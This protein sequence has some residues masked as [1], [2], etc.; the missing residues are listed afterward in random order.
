MRIK[1]FPGG[2][3]PPEEKITSQISI[4]ELS[5]PKRVVIPLSQHTGIPAQPIVKVGDSVKT[6]QKIGEA[7][8]AISSCVHASISGKI[9][10][11][12]KY[13]HPLG[14]GGVAIT[15]DSDGKDE[16]HPSIKHNNNYFRLHPNEIRTIVRQAGIVGL[17]GAAFPTYVKLSPPKDRWIDS[18]ILNGCECEP[19]LTCDHRLMVE[20]TYE[21]IQGLQ[22]MAKTLGD[23]FSYIGIEDNKKDAIGALKGA[24]RNEANIEVVPLKTKYPQGSEKQLIRAV[25]DRRVPSGGLPLD[26]GVVVQNVGT[27]WAIIDAVKRGRPLIE[28]VITVTGPGIKK[29]ANLK[30]RIGTLFQDVIDYCGGFKGKPGKIIMGGPLM[31]F[32]QYTPL[33]PVIKGTTGIVV[34]PREAVEETSPRSCI[35]CARCVDSCPTDIFP[36]LIAQ[37]AGKDKFDWAKEYGALDCIECGVCSYLC[38][39][40]I[41]LVQLIKYAK[42]QIKKL[43]EP[44]S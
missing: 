38:P 37:Y 31:G 29:P 41:P 23:V 22:L 19:Y 15:I 34:L 10:S 39:A 28:R 13:P 25:L 20:R 35:R 16:L 11:I 27:A 3:H 36:N 26:V 40:K 33:V 12:E 1:T 14:P 8:G 18:L 32:A 43:I 4:Q 5:L 17:G 21:I 2:I 6:G 24:L 30:V 44:V 7:Q 9:T 42:I